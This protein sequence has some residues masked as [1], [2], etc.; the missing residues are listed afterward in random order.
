MAV[1][2]NR[3]VYL[4]ELMVVEMAGE[5]AAMAQLKARRYA[6]KYRGSGEPIHLVGVEFSRDTRNV[7][8]FEVE[9][10]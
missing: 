9:R 5:G 1:R 10:W 2:F 3:Q 7:V 4:F 8:G 6:E